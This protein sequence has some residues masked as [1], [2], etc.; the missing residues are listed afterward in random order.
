MCASSLFPMSV[1]TAGV[2]G[3]SVGVIVGTGV[4]D[5]D[6]TQPHA[7]M[8]TNSRKMSMV[9]FMITLRAYPVD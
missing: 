5:G 6:E 3:A 1:G 8:D 9:R 2:D 7:I 4:G